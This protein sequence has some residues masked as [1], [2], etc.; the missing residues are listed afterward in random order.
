MPSL[1]QT[2]SAVLDWM[3]QSGGSMTQALDA[4]GVQDRALRNT[5]LA[6]SVGAT[7]APQ[8]TAPDPLQALNMPIETR[9]EAAGAPVSGVEYTLGAPMPPEAQAAPVAPQQDPFEA[10]NRPISTRDVPMEP[11]SAGGVEV[12]LGASPEE[13]RQGIAEIKRQGEIRRPG[14]KSEEGPVKGRFFDPTALPSGGQVSGSYRGIPGGGGGRLREYQSRYDVA[15]GK[16]MEAAGKGEDALSKAIDEQERAID[17]ERIAAS[18]QAAG[19]A[20]VVSAR[21]RAWEQMQ[22][23]H[24]KRRQEMESRVQ[25]DMDR[26]Q[27]TIQELH[28]STVDPVRFFKHADGTQDYGTTILASVAVAL[29]A[30]GEGLQGRAGNPALDIIQRAIDR[31][32]EAQREDLANRRAEVKM[33]MNLLGRMQ[34]QFADERQAMA[35]TKLAMLQTYEMKL[36]QVAAR[37]KEPAI[38]ARYEKNKADLGLA[39]AK[40]L[41]AFQRASAAQAMQAASAGFGMEAQR[42]QLGMQ[43]AQFAMARQAAAPKAQGRSAP[44]GLELVDPTYAPKEYETKEAQKMRK[45]Y[46]AVESELQELIRWRSEYGAEWFPSEHKTEANTRLNRLKS[47]MRKLDETGANLSPNEVELMGLPEDM[48]D[49]GFV[50]RQLQTVLGSA[51]RATEAGMYGYGYRLGRGRAMTV[52]GEQREPQR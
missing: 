25:D 39:K 16:L 9:M 18:L 12:M 45:A 10:L 37:T 46:A 36:D 35:A 29:G 3:S 1:E 26:L 24:E 50:Q 32:I 19:E 48:G 42:Q 21:Q 2:E 52:P 23:S 33:E 6:R 22:A 28:K 40:E 15:A 17:Q 4:L 43:S 51:R 27:G 13:I 7:Q 11:G 8:S 44:P 5:I 38:L 34:A 49:L 41:D 14:S 30:I 47:A 20:Q 31:D